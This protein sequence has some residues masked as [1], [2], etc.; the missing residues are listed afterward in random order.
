M[1][2]KDKRKLYEAQKRYRQRRRKPPIF[3]DISDKLA[4]AKKKTA[5]N[6]FE[7]RMHSSAYKQL[8]DACK[9]MLSTDQ[10]EHTELKIATYMGMPVVVDD[11]FPF[12][13]AII[14]LTH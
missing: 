4:E 3:N 9:A 8:C 5:S 2:Y 10:R 1:P 13:I 7:L 14:D 12:E 6:D 11:S